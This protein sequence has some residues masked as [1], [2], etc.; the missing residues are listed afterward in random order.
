MHME[1]EAVELTESSH[2]EAVKVQDDTKTAVATPAR[3]WTV[4]YPV[5]TV[6]LA[7]VLI[8]NTI[9]FSSPA[10]LELQQLEDPELQLNTELSDLFGVSGG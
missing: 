8:G 9:G 3:L 6:C 1:A 5:L 7:S 2:A 10:L 4:V